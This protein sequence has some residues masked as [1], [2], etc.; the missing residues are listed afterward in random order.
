[1]FKIYVIHSEVKYVACQL[2]FQVFN[3]AYG[4]F[5]ELTLVNNDWKVLWHNGNIK[6]YGCHE[7]DDYTFFCYQEA[8]KSRY[9]ATLQFVENY[10]Y[11]K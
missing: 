6:I 3:L 8:Y 7:H 10:Q 9:L 2:C 1:M 5:F 11:R 4:L